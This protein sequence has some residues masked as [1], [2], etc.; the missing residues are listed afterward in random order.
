MTHFNKKPQ[1]YLTIVPIRNTQE[2]NDIEGKITLQIPKFKHRWLRKVLVP[3][4]KSSHFRVHLDETGS[5]IWRLINGKRTIEAI[6]LELGNIM[7]NAEKP[8]E[9]TEERV[10]I[11]M[12][13]LYKKK[14][15]LFESQDK[16]VSI[17]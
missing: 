7:Q 17:L 8:M 4:H 16:A 1:N 14:F 5:H 11:F 10:T 2:F 12:T 13:D 6:C 3:K 9:Y 15:I